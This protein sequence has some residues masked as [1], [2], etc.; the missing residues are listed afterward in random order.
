MTECNKVC[1]TRKGAQTALVTL[2]RQH[3]SVLRSYRCKPKLHDGKVV[4]HLTS[5]RGQGFRK[6]RTW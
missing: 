5:S 2:K 6:R 1:Y 4:F 3:R